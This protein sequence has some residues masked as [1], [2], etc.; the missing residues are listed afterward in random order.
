M[1]G[2]DTWIWINKENQEAR[3]RDQTVPPAA[4]LYDGEP[5]D[6]H[7]GVSHCGFCGRVYST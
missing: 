3:E 1:S 4:C 6:A 5:L 7:N 2:F